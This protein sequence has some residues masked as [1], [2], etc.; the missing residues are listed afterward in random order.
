MKC[1]TADLKMRQ[2]L[3]NTKIKNLEDESDLGLDLSEERINEL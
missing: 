3:S 2:K 1:S